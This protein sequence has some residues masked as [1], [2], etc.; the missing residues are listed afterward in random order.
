ML[1]RNLLGQQDENHRDRRL[2]DRLEEAGSA[3]G[4]CG[5][6]AVD[7]HHLPIGLDRRPGGLDSDSLGVGHQECPTG[8]R[9]PD[10]VGMP[11]GASQAAVPIGVVALRP[12]GEDRAGERPGCRGTTRSRWPDEQVG[13]HG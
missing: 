7:D 10:Q 13:V 6:E 5:V 11:A 4:F 3:F 9:H 12:P 1:R 2:L 8:R